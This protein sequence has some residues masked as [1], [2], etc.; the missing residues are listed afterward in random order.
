VELAPVT[1]EDA[2]PAFGGLENVPEYA[3]SMGVG[4]ILDARRIVMMA[5]GDRKA[6][7]VERALGGEI[8]PDVPAS[9]L[10][11]H[12]NVRVVL[13]RDSGAWLCR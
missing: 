3:V 2:A 7:I 4:T 8:G 13:D 6:E 1:R 10:Q 12:G 11:D 9:F 5:W